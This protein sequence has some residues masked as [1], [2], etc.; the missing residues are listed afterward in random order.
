ML[1]CGL[2]SFLMDFTFQTNL[3]GVLLGAAGPVGLNT[4]GILPQMRFRLL[5]YFMAFAI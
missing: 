1:L 4:R 3:E 5:Q 2:T